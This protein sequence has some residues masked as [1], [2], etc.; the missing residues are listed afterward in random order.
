MG[1]VG[2]PEISQWLPAYYLLL[3]GEAE[4]GALAV[5]A[6]D[7]QSGAHEG[8]EALGNA[9]AQTRALDIAVTVFIH[10]LKLFE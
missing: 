4:D 7:H 8:Q 3:Q 10:P 6:S 9:Q 1:F 5:G 2:F